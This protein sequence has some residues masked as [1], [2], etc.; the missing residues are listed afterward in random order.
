M[1]D[2]K[3]FQKRMPSGFD[4]ISVDIVGFCNA[5]CKYCPAGTGP[6]VPQYMTL[7]LLEAILNINL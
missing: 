3:E 4:S 2:L 1:N 7:D 6:K 5:K